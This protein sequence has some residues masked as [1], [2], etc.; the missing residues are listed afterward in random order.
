M[1]TLVKR[2]WCGGAGL[3]P[4][5]VYHCAVMPCYD[6]K[7]EASREDFWLPGGHG[8]CRP[9]ALVV[10]CHAHA[11]RRN[12]SSHLPGL[13][14]RPPTRAGTQVP[15]T[16]SVLATTELQELLEE[17]GVDLR[18]LPPTPFD[19]ILPAAAAAAQQQAPAA[20]NGWHATEQQAQ[21]QQQQQQGA[22][23]A[24]QAQGAQG[25]QQAQQ[26]Q[27]GP[28]APGAAPAS[29]GSGGYLEHVFRAAAAQLFGRPLPPGPAA[30]ERGAQSRP[31]GGGPGSGWCP[32]AAFCCRLWLPKHPG[33]R[34]HQLL[35]RLRLPAASAA[36]RRCV[37]RQARA[38]LP[39]PARP[40]RASCAR[41]SCGA[42]STTTWR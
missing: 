5:R 37:A 31:A 34:G 14:A 15:E 38:A 41:S 3:D 29:S 30:D 2:R 6:K 19:P 25:A 27:L 40:G 42:A 1:G 32:S 11:W 20:S 7:L 12:L 8:L 28:A 39:A 33:G 22:Q 26:A 21:A 36:A 9:A 16:D 17:R 13:T 10:Q 24:Q 18:S 4:A 23:Q 35:P